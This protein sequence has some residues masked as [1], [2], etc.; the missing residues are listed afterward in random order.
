M[1][2]D[3]KTMIALFVDNDHR[4]WYK[5]LPDFR[6][7]YNTAVHSS[8]DVSPAFL[9]FDREPT[10]V[11]SLKVKEKGTPLITPLAAEDWEDRVKRL[12]ALRDLVIHHLY[13]SSDRQAEYYNQ[14]RRD[15]RFNIGDVV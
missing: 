7:A 14:K 13:I 3:P 5:H 11:E 2:R 15:V 12:P 8:T 9:Y 1:N 4:S 10:L 6:F